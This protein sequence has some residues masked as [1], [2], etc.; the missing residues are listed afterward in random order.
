MKKLQRS[1]NAIIGGI[2]SGI[3]EYFN[4]DPT[5]I[6]LLTALLLFTGGGVL[7]YLIAWIIIPSKY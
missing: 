4:I 6:R 5:I 7:L 1:D 3:A 2:C